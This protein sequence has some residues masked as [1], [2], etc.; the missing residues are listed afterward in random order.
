MVVMVTDREAVEIVL[1]VELA[2]LLR[3]HMD[4]HI[5]TH[6]HASVCTHAHAHAHALP[7]YL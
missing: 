4:T 2:C 3:K 7:S 1:P 6:I 5:Y